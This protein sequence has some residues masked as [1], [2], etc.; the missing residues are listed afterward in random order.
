MVID[1]FPG[2]APV[3]EFEGVERARFEADIQPAGE[4]AVLRGLVNDWPLL[5]ASRQGADVLADRLK[6]TAPDTLVRTFRQPH[7]TGTRFFYKDDFSGFTFD[8][9]TPPLGALLD[10]LL[11][12]QDATEPDAVFAG[13]VP[14]REALEPIARDNA[15]PLLDPDVERLT[16]L[17]IGNQTRTAPHWDLPQNLACVVSGRRRFLLFPIEQLANLYIGPL[18]VTLAGQ[19]VSLVDPR[20]PDLD[21]FPRFA[22]AMQQARLAE[23]GPG[24]ALYMPSMQVHYVETLDPF[25]IMMN[26]W[27]RDGPEH[28][29]TPFL[30]LLHGLLTLRGMPARER[31]A[32]KLI[33]DRYLFQDDE[34]PM[35]HLPPS[36]RGLFGDPTPETLARIRA[37][38]GRPLNR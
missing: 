24:D 16:S 15:M 11:S 30:T 13:G 6:Q 8:V 31:Q 18:D 32:W 25:G 29:A 7:A 2:I 23:L 22:E 28:L 33:F 3:A 1:G 17:W 9:E 12:G 19:P 37:I 21:R 20:A 10:T 38:V 35:A 26:F 5:A 4:P 27:W 36:A 34:D 14:V